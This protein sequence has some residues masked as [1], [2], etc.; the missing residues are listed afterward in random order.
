MIEKPVNFR[1]MIKGDWYGTVP[2]R[3]LLVE[4]PEREQQM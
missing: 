4:M 3:Y 2:Y 1:K